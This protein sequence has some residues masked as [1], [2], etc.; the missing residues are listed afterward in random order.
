MA[1]LGIKL[2]LRRSAPIS[3]SLIGGMALSCV[4]D[5]AT[6]IA[7]MA[8]G[9]GVEDGVCRG[10][11]SRGTFVKTMP[12]TNFMYWLLIWV[13]WAHNASGDQ[14]E[15]NYH[16]EWKVGEVLK[17]D[18]YGLL[19]QHDTGF[20]M[21]QAYYQ[22][23]QVR[24]LG[25]GSGQGQT[26]P[27]SS[28]AQ[29]DEPYPRPTPRLGNTGLMSQQE[30]LGFLRSQLGDNPWG[31][32]RARVMAELVRQIKARG[33]DYHHSATPSAY[34]TELS[35]YGA[36]SEVTRPLG[37][38]YGPPPSRDQLLGTWQTEVNAPHVYYTKGNE[39]WRRNDQVQKLGSLSINP[40]GSYSWKSVTGQVIQGS[41]RLATE[42]EMQTAGGEGLVLQ[43]GKSGF[44]WI[45]TKYRE[46]T[47]PNMSPD[48][49]SIAEITTRQQREFG[50]R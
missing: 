38:N 28:Q 21:A 11:P 31:P 41:W 30:V 18:Q 24:P 14:V 40:E 27:A 6:L 50:N 3:D 2:N 32:N 34:Y 9:L 22:A 15:F 5:Y 36:T 19:I 7:P 26:Q 4:R 39:L 1:P 10:E 12:R 47:P 35:K 37:D 33:L 48:W 29:P 16:G 17:T 8:L 42:T 23:N 25:A 49:I 20:G 44:D 43:R 46:A 45:V 13:A